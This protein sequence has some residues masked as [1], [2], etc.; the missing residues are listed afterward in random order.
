[1]NFRC[2]DQTETDGFGALDQRV[3]QGEHENGR[4]DNG[5]ERD[6]SGDM[7]FKAALSTGVVR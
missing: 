1:M 5:I 6:W 4:L 3:G 7:D 2:V